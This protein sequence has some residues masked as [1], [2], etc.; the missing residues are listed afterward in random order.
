MIVLPAGTFRLSG[1]VVE[2]NTPA[3]VLSG[4][5]VE[6]TDGPR[7]GLSATTLSNGSY[8]LYGLSGDTQMRVTRNGFQPLVLNVPVSGH[9]TQNFDLSP[10]RPRSRGRGE[11]VAG[12]YLHQSGWCCGH[13]R[14]AFRPV[15][16]THRVVPHH[17]G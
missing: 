16:N 8:R 2:S 6:V 7:A 5:R 15:W 17:Q 4:A 11:A 14:V 13:E 3:A 9:Q 1:I 12:G 10:V